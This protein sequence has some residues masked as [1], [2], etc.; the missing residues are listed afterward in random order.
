MDVPVQGIGMMAL[1]LL[2]TPL[3]GRRKKTSVAKK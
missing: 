2:L 1:S 3:L